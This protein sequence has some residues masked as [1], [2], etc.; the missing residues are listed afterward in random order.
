MDVPSGMAITTCTMGVSGS[1]LNGSRMM[2]Y[3]RAGPEVPEL[4]LVR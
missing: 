4:W 2:V 1:C 3:L